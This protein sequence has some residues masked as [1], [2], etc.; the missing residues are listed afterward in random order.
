MPRTRRYF[1][2]KQ[3]YEVIFRARQGLPL[4][5][6]KIIE[7]LILSALARTQRD[8]KVVICHHMWM[9]NHAHIGCIPYDVEAFVAFYQ[10]LQKKITDSLKQLLGLTHLQIWQ[11]EPV[12]AIIRDPQAA[13]DKIAYW[14]AN[15][16]RANL[17][18]TISDYPGTSSWKDFQQCT[19]SVDAVV[20]REVPWIRLLAISKLPSPKLTERQD[21]FITE[22]LK[23]T[24]TKTHTLTLRPNAWME[25]FGITEP[26]EVVK[27]NERVKVALSEKEEAARTLRE[28]DKKSVAGANRLKQQKILREYTPKRSKDERRVVVISSQKELRMEFIAT[29]RR[30][31]EICAALYQRWKAGDFSV[32]WPP[33]VFRPSSPP[34][35]SLFI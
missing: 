28:K 4:P 32:T 24:A 10:E 35:A 9:G 3:F 14:Y 29:V 1:P 13:L 12:V 19:S 6:L 2:S 22:K 30:I 31:S 8:N 17:V 7:L 25:L 26:E 34:I 20:T 21:S 33:G 23:T 15:P 27:W 16:A 18:D 5:T 11:G